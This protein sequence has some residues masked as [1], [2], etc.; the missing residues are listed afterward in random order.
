MTKII[1]HF[2]NDA[3]ISLTIANCVKNCSINRNSREM[4]V[5]S[6]FH[7][8]IIQLLSKHRTNEEIFKSLIGSLWNISIDMNIIEDLIQMKVLHFCKRA[9]EDTFKENENVIVL[10][11]GF[12][13]IIIHS[14]NVI[15]PLKQECLKGLQQLKLKDSNSQQ[16]LDKLLQQLN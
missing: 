10:I 5:Q 11:I 6:K 16:K 9:I 4:I 3:K 15:E 13:S 12:F 8:Q 7:I 14:K 2:E 1:T